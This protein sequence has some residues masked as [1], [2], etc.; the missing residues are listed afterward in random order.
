M[1]KTNLAYDQWVYSFGICARSLR[2]RTKIDILKSY[3]IMQRTWEKKMILLK[4]AIETLFETERNRIRYKKRD[5][6]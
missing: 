4:M 3:T 6:L 1:E 5:I 2:K